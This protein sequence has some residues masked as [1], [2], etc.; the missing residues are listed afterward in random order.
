MPITLHRFSQ[1]KCLVNLSSPLAQELA[2]H[3]LVV[4]DVEHVVE[5]TSALSNSEI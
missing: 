4:H 1:E 2:V 5:S 3:E